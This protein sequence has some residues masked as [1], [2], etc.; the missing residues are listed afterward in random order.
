[1]GQGRLPE[2]AMSILRPEMY[3]EQL[4]KGCSEVV[5]AGVCVGGDASRRRDADV[6]WGQWE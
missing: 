3:G 5:W 2:E 4:A 6:F 1:M